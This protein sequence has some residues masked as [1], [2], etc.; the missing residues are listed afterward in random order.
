M[1]DCFVFR[2][3]S[4]I[5]RRWHTEAVY[6]YLRKQFER[7][8][9][10]RTLI[11]FDIEFALP[12]PAR[13]SKVSQRPSNEKHSIFFS[14]P[15]IQHVLVSLFS[16]E[17]DVLFGDHRV[18]AGH[19]L[20]KTCVDSFIMI[21]VRLQ[22]RARYVWRIVNIRQLHVRSVLRQYNRVGQVNLVFY[23]LRC[24]VTIWNCTRRRVLSEE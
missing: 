13:R 2:I 7:L 18:C 3:N 21:Q 10:T 1:F 6:V 15:V 22:I 9:F 16:N 23:D 12:F 14:K 20:L 11:F 4:V 24:F 19:E 8:I 5:T 17:R